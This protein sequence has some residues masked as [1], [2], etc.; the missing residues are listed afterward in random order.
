VKK[1]VLAA[2]FAAFVLLPASC[3][4]GTGGGES[5]GVDHE[6][7]NHS[8]GGH[9]GSTDVVGRSVAASEAFVQP[10]GEYSDAAFVDAMVAHHQEAVEMAELALWSAEHEEMRGLAG[11]IVVARKG[12]LRALND[13]LP[14][15]PNTTGSEA[16][17]AT[18]AGELAGA[19]PFDLT[20][21]EAMT[22]HHESA[23]AMAN[24]A[25][26]ESEDPQVRQIARSIADAHE[27]EVAKMVRWREEWYPR[28]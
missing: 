27:R 7:T 12:E 8:N 20:F 4:S 3:G 19:E 22:A 25:L 17:E 1:Y 26:E 10:G 14:E 6:S 28:N 23:V 15:T 24:V 2:L 13:L 11:E 18:G 5:G 16:T 9:D 21:I